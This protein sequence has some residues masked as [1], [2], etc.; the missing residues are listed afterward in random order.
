MRTLMMCAEALARVV[1]LVYDMSGTADGRLTV[2]RDTATAVFKAASIRLDRHECGPST[3]Q[4]S[5]DGCLGPL[6]ADVV[7]LRIVNAPPTI[8]S[9]V[10]GQALLPPR[11]ERGVLAT[12]FADRVET[13]AALAHVDPGRLLGRV[14]AHEIAHLLMTTPTHTSTGRMRAEWSADEMRGDGEEHESWTVQLATAVGQ[15]VRAR[16]ATSTTP[17]CRAGAKCP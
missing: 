13:T 17:T 5:D 2:A 15:C 9:R 16:P 7:R 3:S 1:V 8:R 12:V 11:G 14:A 4:R 10:L 6:G